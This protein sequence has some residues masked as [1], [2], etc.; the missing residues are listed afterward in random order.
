MV[1]IL[2]TLFTPRWVVPFLVGTLILSWMADRWWPMLWGGVGVLVF[3][4][5]KK[6]YEAPWRHTNEASHH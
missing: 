5:L 4:A 3:L 6:L 2:R 1:P